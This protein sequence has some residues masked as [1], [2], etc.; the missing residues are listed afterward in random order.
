MVI[1]RLEYHILEMASQNVP[2]PFPIKTYK[3]QI[4][5]G[6]TGRDLCTV[7]RDE[8]SSLVAHALAIHLAKLT[9]LLS[10]ANLLS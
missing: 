6:I 5:C 2:F 10:A 8:W 7:Q 3:R 1:K 9:K 4:N